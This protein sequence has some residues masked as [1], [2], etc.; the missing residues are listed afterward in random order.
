MRTT[1]CGV[2]MLVVGTVCVARAADR[3]A[4]EWV[5]HGA[6]R[7]L[8][9][10]TTERGD[11][12]MD[13][14][15]AGYRG[16]GVAIPDV[17]VKRTVKPSGGDD[18]TKIIQAAIDEVAKLPIGENRFRGAVMLEP[19]VFLCAETI[20]ITASGVVLRGSGSDGAQRS[21][22][23]MTG[24]PHLAIAARFS[25]RRGS[26]SASRPTSRDAAAET[27]TTISDA[28]VPSGA[29]SFTVSDASKFRVGD[30]IVIRRP[31]T[32]AWVESMQMHDLVRDGK[33]QTWLK[34]GTTTD[35]ERA[36]AAIDGNTITLDVPLSDS[37]DLT[38]LDPP[39]TIVAK[40]SSAPPRLANVGIENLHIESPPQAIS[41]SKPHHTAIRLSG[42]DCWIRDVRSDE[43][44]NSIS[45]GGRR[46]TVQEVHVTRK[47]KHEGASKPAEIAPNGSQVLLD[48]C[49]VT[50]EN[51][52]HVATGGGIAGPIVVLNCDFRGAGK[53]ESHQR[54]ST[55]LLYDNCRATGGAGFEMRN[56]GSMGSGHGWSMGWGVMWN[57]RGDSFLAQNPPGVHNWMIGCVGERKTAPRPFG[58]GPALAEATVDS[59]GTPVAPSSLYLAQL[60]E[61]L[62]RRALKNIGYESAEPSPATA[63]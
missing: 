42:E 57:C 51:V 29:I 1:W 32:K 28:Y 3:P 45:V 18:D 10:N 48:R 12:I 26:G 22:I 15:Y 39:G 33:P 46:I 7:K 23:K 53:S 11:R 19:G 40:L 4:S 62:G 14:S 44:M 17:A 38:F 16:G 2:A 36:I 54:W 31:V 58:S 61:R 35:A 41:H 6:D 8:A 63:P 60:E 37:F 47:A 24:D 34:A 5:R 56:R 49:S 43:T 59:H 13:F 25:G 50:G 20:V 52:W 30:A 27:Q 9:Y 21:T 55:G